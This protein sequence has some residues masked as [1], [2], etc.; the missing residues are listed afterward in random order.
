MHQIPCWGPIHFRRLLQ[1]LVARATWLSGKSTPL[2]SNAVSK[3]FVVNCEMWFAAPQQGQTIRCAFC[4]N[5]SHLEYRLIICR[6]ECVELILGAYDFIVWCFINTKVFHLAFHLYLPS[7]IAWN[8]ADTHRRRGWSLIVA[9]RIIVWRILAVL[10][11][12]C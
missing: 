11:N 5:S 8:G 2:L 1:N 3:P 7:D 6:S 12:S 9:C 10:G 4:G